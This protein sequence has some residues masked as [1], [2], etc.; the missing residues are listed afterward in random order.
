MP[1]VKVEG[2]T[3]FSRDWYRP[4]MTEP[5]KV[6]VVMMTKYIPLMYLNV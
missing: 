1:P 2:P 5:M 6:M 3:Y 4:S